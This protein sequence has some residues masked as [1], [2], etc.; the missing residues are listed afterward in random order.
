MEKE[1]FEK[2]FLLDTEIDKLKHNLNKFKEI[3]NDITENPSAFHIYLNGHDVFM[4]DDKVISLF[5]ENMIKGMEQVINK[6][7]EEFKKL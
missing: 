2:A 1:Q 3:A 6:K 7:E 5:L 4:E